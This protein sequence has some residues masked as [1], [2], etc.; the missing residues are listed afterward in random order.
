MGARVSISAKRTRTTTAPTYTSTRTRATSSAPSTSREP[1]TPSSATTSHSAAWTTWRVVTA[2][3]PP[4]TATTAQAAKAVSRAVT[5]GPRWAARAP[6]PASPPPV[7]HRPPAGPGRPWSRCADARSGAAVPRR[8][9]RRPGPVPRGGREAAATSAGSA[10]RS[11]RAGG[12]GTVAIQSPSRSFSWSRSRMSVSAYSNWGLQKSAS[13]GHTSMQ[14]PQYMHSEK[15]MAK[16][17]RTLRCRSRPPG[18]RRGHRLLVGVDVDAPVRALAGAEH[19]RGAVLLEQRDDAAAAGRAGRVG[20]P[21]TRRCAR[22]AARCGR[23]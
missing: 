22:D 13:N 20:R 4:T 1:A 3:R 23:W 17:S 11:S 19:A 9:P 15:S 7:P 8:R 10:D 6:R 14:M 21:G 16:R 18:V 12:G 5:R 2:N